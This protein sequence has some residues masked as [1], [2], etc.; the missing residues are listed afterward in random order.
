[1]LLHRLSRAVLG[2]PQLGGRATLALPP[3][4]GSAMVFVGAGATAIL[5][6]PLQPSHPTL[7]APASKSSSSPPDATINGT[8][9]LEAL[10]LD[11][12]KP[13]MQMFGVSGFT[14][15]TAGYAFK[16][17]F[18]VF[19][20]S[21]GCC[22]IGLQSL[23]SNGFITVHWEAMEKQFHRLADLDG[24]GKVD[25]KDIKDGY[26]RVLAYL[27]AGAPSVGGFS[28]GFLVGLRS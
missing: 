11:V 9:L 4:V 18:K 6:Q 28:T 27:S 3:R 22:F 15:Y 23:A 8:T 1:M 21:F 16:R 14:G 25:E 12:L 10:N 7:C 5:P 13:Q 20:L 19:F 24:D 2:A 26:D 17:A